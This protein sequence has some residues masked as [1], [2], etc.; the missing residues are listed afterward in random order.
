MHFDEALS[1]MDNADLEA[2]VPANSGSVLER[3]DGTCS[4][5]WF[6]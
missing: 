3:S 1:S 5:D 6:L 2:A 4:S